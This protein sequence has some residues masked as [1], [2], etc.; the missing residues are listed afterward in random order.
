MNDKIN[1][2]KM[3]GLATAVLILGGLVLWGVPYY[4]AGTVRA[5]VTK[6]LKA[7]PPNPHPI[8]AVEVGALTTKV[9][10]TEAT[11]LRIEKAMIARDAVILKYFQ[12]KAG[13][14]DGT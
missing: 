7:L 11:V 6:E 8:T 5:Q 1:V 2:G 9:E 3:V 10:N 14:A 12:D 13:E 4:I